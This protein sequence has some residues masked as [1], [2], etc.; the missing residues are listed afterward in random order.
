MDAGALTTLISNL[1]FP[2]ACVIAMFWMWNKEREDH[3]QEM[4][5]VTTAVTNNTIAV[6]SLVN[7]LKAEREAAHNEQN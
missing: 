4:K 2:I 6:N 3:K 7:S 5:E 1:G